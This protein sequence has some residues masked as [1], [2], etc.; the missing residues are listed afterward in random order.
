MSA[1]RHFKFGS[2]EALQMRLTSTGESATILLSHGAT[3]QSLCLGPDALEV[4][5]ADSVDELDLNP[6]F[7]GRLLFPFNDRIPQATY[8]FGGKS[9]Q[10]PVNC[11]EDG[12]AIHGL[13]Y[14]RAFKVLSGE[15]SADQVRVVLQDEW[16]ENQ[17]PGYPWSLRFLVK[18]TLSAG[19]FRLDFEIS[20]ESTQTA[21]VA[22]GWHPY[23]RLDP[24]QSLGQHS[25]E[26]PAE[27][28][29]AVD[30]SLLPTGEEPSCAGTPLDF[31]QAQN[32]SEIELDV[33][34]TATG[35]AVL[36]C[37]QRTLRLEQDPEFFRYV[38]LYT[39]ETRTSIAIEPV[40]GATDSF[41]RPALG[42]TD[43]AP[44]QVCRT[45]CQIRMDA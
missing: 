42:R 30:E 26:L 38:Q 36:R 5:E 15:A 9:F 45:W 7:R 6:K 11:P 37:G 24:E 35:P 43:L 10:L 33:A 32:L 34:L 27:S 18:A 41:N 40:S 14:N 20:N 22:L 44:A 21:P 31:S 12:S 25:L 17:W 3:I 29:V 19:C 8:V 28:F 4:L 13:V 1:L 16:P 23:F 39:P 2:A